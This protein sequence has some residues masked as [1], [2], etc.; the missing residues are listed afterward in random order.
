MIVREAKEFEFAPEANRV[1]DETTHNIPV[2]QSLIFNLLQFYDA[3]QM[4]KLQKKSLKLAEIG[5]W[6]SRK[7]AISIV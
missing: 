6:G 2:S 1:I 5:S 3:Y 7:E 4:M